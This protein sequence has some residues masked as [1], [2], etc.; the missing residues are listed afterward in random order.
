MENWLFWGIGSCMFRSL[1]FFR[2]SE[3]AD[4]YTAVVSLLDLIF[5][6]NLKL[7]YINA[8]CKTYPPT[9]RIIA[10]NGLEKVI[11]RLTWGGARLFPM[12]TKTA[13]G[14]QA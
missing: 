7:A 4:D 2:W 8:I 13:I 1:L 14:M 10:F 3:L 12:I 6:I 9:I 11:I 5:S